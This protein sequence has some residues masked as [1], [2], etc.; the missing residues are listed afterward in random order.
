MTRQLD[1]NR[2]DCGHVGRESDSYKAKAKAF[3]R[4]AEIRGAKV[5]DQAKKCPDCK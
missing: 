2:Y 1:L 5:E 4:V 3:I